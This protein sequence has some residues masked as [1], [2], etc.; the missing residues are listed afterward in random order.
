IAVFAIMAVLV[1]VECG[2]GHGGYG[3]GGGGDGAG[4]G[5]GGD[6]ADTPVVHTGSVVSKVFGPPPTPHFQPVAVPQHGYDRVIYSKPV[7]GYDKGHGH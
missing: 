5:D 7:Q 3:G 4:A 2:G 6:G 1:S